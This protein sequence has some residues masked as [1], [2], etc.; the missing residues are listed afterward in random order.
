MGAIAPPSRKNLAFL[1]E[2]ENQSKLY[3]DMN[4]TR[5]L[6]PFSKR[7]LMIK[8]ALVIFY[9]QQCDIGTNVKCVCVIIISIHVMFLLYFLVQNIEQL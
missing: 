3:V 9:N 1:K 6:A 2:H 4:G 7:L 5:V 8:P